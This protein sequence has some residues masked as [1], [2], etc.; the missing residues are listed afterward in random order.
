MAHN[1]FGDRLQTAVRN[2]WSVLVSAFGGGLAWALGSPPIV[3]IGA[4]GVMFATAVTVSAVTSAPGERRLP[5]RPGTRQQEL[6]TLLDGHVRSLRVL[7]TRSLPGAVQMRAADALTAA[8]RARPSVLQVAS[9]VDALD[10]AVAAARKVAA[11]GRHATEAI[12]E[13]VVRLKARR[14]ELLDRLTAAVDEVATVYAGLVELSA[15]ARM[16]GVTFDDSEVSAVND[17]VTLLQMA[18]A[19]LEADAAAMPTDTML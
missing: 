7:A 13:T 16:M 15:T 19:E 6:V 18:F 14:N 12:R 8:D 9:A 4:V 17:S 3:A 1:H 10:E 5:L 2:P 11:Q